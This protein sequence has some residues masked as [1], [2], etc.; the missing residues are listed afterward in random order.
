[1]KPQLTLQTPLELPPEEISTYLKQL[2]ISE[3]EY[4]S[5]AN[6]FSLIVW[7]PS[8]LEQYLVKSKLING[9]ITGNLSPEIIEISKK[10]VLENGLPLST[11]LNSDE[12]I[13]LLKQNKLEVKVE[14]LRGQFFESSISTLNPRRLIT[15]APTND[16]GTELK[17][18]VSAYCPLGDDSREQP[19]CGDLVVIRGD[20]K[21]ISSK[22]SKIIED[23]CIDELPT[24]LW[25]NSSLDDSPDIFDNFS[26]TGK[27]L[28]ID[29]ANGKEKRCLNVLRK[30]LN[31]K[32]AV[33]DLNW[34]RLKSWRES[35]AMIFDP[36]GRREILN[37]ISEVDVDI[38][39]EHTIQAIF[40]IAWISDKLN[41]TII[42]ASKKSDFVNIEFSRKNGE[43]IKININSVPLGNP[44]IHSGQVIGLRLISKISEDPKKNTCIIL[45][46]ESAECMRLE[47]G[48]MADMQLIEAVVP[49][50]Y[51]SSESDVSKLLASSRGNTSPLFENAINI[52][53]KIFDTINLQ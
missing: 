18:F 22:G 38:E 3:N 39:G 35:L 29:T 47:A 21:S 23:L 14:D 20:A 11:S 48:G 25:W 46:S 26:T 33:N 44:S 40:L 36:P 27:R 31:S 53:S 34:V 42:S 8:W 24:W 43:K 19:I 50:Y 5:G 49:N 4:S 12:L 9:P 2:W 1:M 30:V 15:L 7:Q 6:T 51:F 41:W 17:T 28:I 37:H 45:G 13:D 32:K 52:S 16:E 10:L